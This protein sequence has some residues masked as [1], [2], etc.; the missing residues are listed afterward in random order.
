MHFQRFACLLIV[1][2]SISFASSSWAVTDCLS[3]F[4]KLLSDEDR[5]EIRAGAGFIHSHNSNF[6]K[7]QS[8]QTRAARFGLTGSSNPVDKLESW[9]I[10]MERAKSRPL[11]WQKIKSRMLDKFVTRE[12]PESYFASLQKRNRE[13]GLGDTEFTSE[14]KQEI[15][16]RIQ[17]DQRESL[18]QWIDYFFSEDTKTYPTWAKIWAFGQMVRLG[19]FNRELAKFSKRS[20]SS[21][22]PF[23]ELNR[24][25][26]AH[27]LGGVVKM[28]R[29]E[30][31]LES[32]N[33]GK[34][35]ARA[36]SRLAKNEGDIG[37]VR[38]KWVKYERG[39]DHRSLLASLCDKNTGWCTAQEGF[40]KSHLESGDFHV[41]Y[42]NDK[43]GLPT[44]PRIAIR[45]KGE[46][47]GEIRGVGRDQNLDAEI[48]QSGILE[49]KLKEFG[50]QGELYFKRLEH[51]RKLT[52]IEGKS[53]SGEKLTKNEIR[54]LYEIDEK[55][56][57]FGYRDDPRIAEIIDVRDTRE[58]LAYL[59]DTE[60]ERVSL[61]KE[62]A[63]SGNIDYHHGDLS[64]SD[65]MKK[66]N[67]VLP[68]RVGGNLD[69]KGLS[70]AD[71]LVLPS[72]QKVIVKDRGHW[73]ELIGSVRHQAARKTLLKELL[74]GHP[75]FDLALKLSLKALDS[76][77]I[78]N[79]KLLL[80][81][82][83]IDDLDFTRLDHVAKVYPIFKGTGL[84]D[85]FME[86]DIMEQWIKKIESDKTVARRLSRYL[87]S[88]VVRRVLAVQRDTDSEL[89]KLYRR[90]LGEH[91][92][93]GGELQDIVE[94]W[95]ES[96]RDIAL[97]GEFLLAQIG[98]SNNQFK[99]YLELVPQGQHAKLWESIDKE[100]SLSPYLKFARERGLEERL[101]TRAVLESFEFQEIMMPDGHRFEMQVTPETQIKIETVL[102]KNPS[103][104][105][106]DNRPVETMSWDEAQEYVIK[107][108][109]SLGLAGCDGTPRSAKGCYRLATEEEWEYAMR[110]G[111]RTTYF[112]GDDPAPLPRYAVFGK[113]SKEGTSPVASKRANS[114]GLHDMA[115]NVWEW[116]QD[117]WSSSMQRGFDHLHSS[118]GSTRVVR[119][120]SWLINA[121]NL[122]SAYR[123]SSR[124]GLGN[125]DVGF[126]VVRT[127]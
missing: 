56:E 98:A 58:D 92:S 62:E 53:G 93:G 29:G 51:M 125:Y 112:V 41:Y 40:A 63:L 110:G 118:S 73:I 67:L 12:V 26:L 76:Q 94:M 109:E 10:A 105:K 23:A 2:W 70:S 116:V 81:I 108:N 83:E 42:S 38:G 20:G 86:E 34:L 14:Q 13:R 54:F 52:E 122:R 22:A 69:L 9:L 90:L 100:S 44:R 117:Q 61:T 78:P 84:E 7:D 115:G 28:A 106:G 99:R 66:Q 111:T 123:V 97:K 4:S 57:G 107:L 87:D 85:F 43:D 35:Y 68:V 5:L 46:E 15:T 18:S 37:E 103:Y 89:L 120:G 8:V 72:A 127:L 77:D 88:P 101:L 48:A 33:F 45:M 60:P 11:A 119:G 59:F 55:I 96:S 32:Q 27:V 36:I 124:P 74:R 64:V 17:R 75:E 3:R 95:L 30:E 71:G 104:F 126:R 24:E 82:S 1:S 113:S 91:K 79:D 121:Q 19:D 16:Q 6:H 114:Y 21:I 102:G 39:S 65:S 80:V 49:N 31:A 25:A 47:I 50:S